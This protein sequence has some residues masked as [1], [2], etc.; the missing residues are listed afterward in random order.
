LNPRVLITREPDRAAPL[1]E[2]LQRAGVA[3]LAKAV[4]RTVYLP[5]SEPLPDLGQFRWLAF[6][7]VNGVKG[8]ARMMT[9]ETKLPD[10][11]RIAVVGPATE[12]AAKKLLRNPDLAIEDTDAAGLARQILIERAAHDGETVLWPCAMK[13]EPAFESNLRKAGME[14]LPWLVYRTEAIEAEPLH[15]ALKLFWPWDAVIFGA[16]SAVKAFEKAWPTPWDFKAIAIGQ[17][18]ARALSEIPD[19]V[20]T[21]SEGTSPEDLRDAVLESL[22][23]K[24]S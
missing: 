18:T 14:V 8:F 13:F 7:S 5:Q 1:I 6:T 11:M 24:V 15:S 9:G 22:S 4:T 12:A 2:L 3:A 16:P 17:T 10:S 19:C 23:M 21:I 20:P